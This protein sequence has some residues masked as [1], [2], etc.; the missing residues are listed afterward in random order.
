MSI[1]SSQTNYFI[2]L[3]YC[4]L[5]SFPRK[6]GILSTVI[7]MDIDKKRIGKRIRHRR[8]AAGLSQEQL[9]EKLD[10]STNHISSMECGKSLLTTKRLLDLCDILGGT[11]NYYLLGEIEPEADRITSL[12]KKLPPD[13]Q[14]MLCRLI[15]T[16]LHG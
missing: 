7:G 8:E 14:E 1:K 11:P 12:V 3:F 10:L 2:D 4:S 15:E 13:A 6:H 5:F 9:A 16:Y